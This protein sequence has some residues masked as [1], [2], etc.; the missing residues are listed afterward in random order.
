MKRYR[1][2][3]GTVHLYREY[4]PRKLDRVVDN[5]MNLETEQLW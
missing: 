4:I 5:A 2:V 1:V 3:R